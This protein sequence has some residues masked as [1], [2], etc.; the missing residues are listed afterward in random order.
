MALCQSIKV[1]NCLGHRNQDMTCKTHTAAGM[2]I[3][4]LKQTY[5]GPRMMTLKF[6]GI[7]QIICET[8]PLLNIKS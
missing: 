6:S 1:E 4:E 8:W 3:A 2:G 5:S 7:F